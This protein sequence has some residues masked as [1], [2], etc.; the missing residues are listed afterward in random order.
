MN[1]KITVW[2]FTV[3]V[4]L[5]SIGTAILIIPS[6]LI[7]IARQD[8]WLSAV[9]GTGLGLGLAALYNAVGQRFPELTFTQMIENVFGQWVGKAISIT[10]IFFA[11]ITAAELLY[12]MGVFMIAQIIPDT[13]IAAV[14]VTFAAIIV[15]SVRLGIPTLARSAEILFIFFLFLFIF[16]VLLTTPQIELQQL[17]PVLQT[18]IMPILN[19]SILYTSIFSLSPVVFLMIY[20][21][22]V[23][24]G[25]EAR[26]SFYIGTFIGGIVLIIMILLPILVL[27]TEIA[28]NQIF[29]SYILAKMIRIGSFA[30]RIEVIMAAMWFIT[31]YYKM[32]LYFYA[33]VHGLAQT[34]HLRDYRAIIMPIAL[35][36][37]V[38]S[39]LVHPNFSHTKTY[40]T[41]TW[42]PYAATYG[43]VLPILLLIGASIKK[44]QEKN[45]K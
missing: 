19:A 11:L 7:E 42:L 6:S 25:K 5:F 8:A 3:L 28:A 10:F 26:R 14:S 30:E 32:T 17:K 45:K 27:G 20:P 40:N 39:L 21:S 35:F 23:H 22:A 44:S 9:I 2:Q 15:L 24:G 18:G 12:Y 13:P 33:S 31:I 36:L 1:Q 16:F 29:P 4:I 41:E 43:F 34:F 37:I 38:F